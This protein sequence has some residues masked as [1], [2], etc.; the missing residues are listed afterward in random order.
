MPFLAPL[1]NIHIRLLFVFRFPVFDLPEHT[2]LI[3]L[4]G[5]GSGR[6][7]QRD[8]I[9]VVV[10]DR[11]QL[12]DPGV[13]GVI[14]VRLALIPS[15]KAPATVP[16]TVRLLPVAVANLA[17]L[18]RDAVSGDAAIGTFPVGKQKFHIFRLY[19]VV[20]VTAR[21]FVQL[22]PQHLHLIS[23]IRDLILSHHLAKVVFQRGMDKVRQGLIHGLVFLWRGCD[24]DTAGWSVVL[25]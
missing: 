24:T 3:P 9:G 14:H 4:K 22:F 7:Q 10:A 19:M 5:A 13:V 11:I 12:V 21:G 20:P 17:A 8:N 6:M 18:H 25:I 16:A 1:Q 23:H 2:I 15:S